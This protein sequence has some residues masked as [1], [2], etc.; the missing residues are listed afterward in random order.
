MNVNCSRNNS[1]PDFLGRSN[2]ESYRCMYNFKVGKRSECNKQVQ[3]K[4]DDEAR[5]CEPN[6]IVFRYN[7][8]VKTFSGCI[9]S[10]IGKKNLLRSSLSQN[11]VYYSTYERRRC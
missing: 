7:P 10:D 6:P 5:A 3:E 9:N 4:V 2:S 1:V 11:N 8:D